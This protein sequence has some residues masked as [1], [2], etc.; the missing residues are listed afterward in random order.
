VPGAVLS[1]HR[2]ERQAWTE[3]LA[4]AERFAIGLARRP[5]LSVRLVIGEP[6]VIA[7][8]HACRGRIRQ[9]EPATRSG[10]RRERVGRPATASSVRPSVGARRSFRTI[11][12]SGQNQRR[13]AQQPK[14]VHPGDH[15]HQLSVA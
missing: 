13:R 12:Q 1:P 2:P 6:P 7:E 4:R 3:P 10:R 8:S 11:A 5:P 15:Q 14:K 9:R